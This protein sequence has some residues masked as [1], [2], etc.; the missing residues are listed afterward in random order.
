[1]K[2]RVLGHAAEDRLWVQ[3]PNEIAQLDVEDVVGF[4]EIESE[5]DEQVRGSA[6]ASRGSRRADSHHIALRGEVHG[7]LSPAEEDLLKELDRYPEGLPVKSIKKQLV[8]SLFQKGYLEWAPGGKV[9]T[10]GVFASRR[11]GN[12]SLITFDGVDEADREAWR[13]VEDEYEDEEGDLEFIP[14]IPDFLN[15]DPVVTDDHLTDAV[16]SGE[17][18]SEQDPR[19]K[20]EEGDGDY[21]ECP[22]SMEVIMSVEPGDMTDLIEDYLSAS[23]REAILGLGSWKPKQKWQKVKDP[24]TGKQYT[25]ETSATFGYNL[26]NDS[27]V[28]KFLMKKGMNQTDINTFSR[29][30][31]HQLDTAKERA[32]K[33]QPEGWQGIKEAPNAKWGQKTGITYGIPP[34]MTQEQRIFYNAMKPQ[35]R[36][37]LLKMTPEQQQQFWAQAVSK[38]PQYFKSAT[39][40]AL[41]PA[42]PQGPGGY[43]KGV[44]PAASRSLKR[45]KNHANLVGGILAMPR[46]AGVIRQA[47]DLVSAVHELDDGESLDK[48]TRSAIRNT[49]HNLLMATDH[50]KGVNNR[51]ANRV[52]G[53]IEQLYVESLS[54]N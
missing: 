32:Y 20:V 39:Q 11:A 27:D 34:K 48:T 52:A 10:L 46:T 47:V 35:G 49:S 51:I 17:L 3:L 15:G 21:D 37:K 53:E 54:A 28:Q 22:E 2:G 41:S 38:Y 45:M 43:F 30:R 44:T 33:I 7:T 1:V 12:A 18:P 36:Q 19:D 29:V 42:F 13:G 50:L 25:S 14:D 8:D 24:T 6:I 16:H 23:R 31:Q 9:R 5:M 40:P 26:F 4:H